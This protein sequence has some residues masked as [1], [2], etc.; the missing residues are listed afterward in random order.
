MIRREW[1]LEAEGQVT[2]EKSVFKPN[3]QRGRIDVHVNPGDPSVGVAVGEVKST[4]WEQMTEPAV[5]RNVRRQAKQIWAY[6]ESQLAE[7]HAVSPGVIF[8]ARPKSEVSNRSLIARAL[9]LSG[10][11]QRISE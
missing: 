7:G 3:G 8:P 6:I 10:A 2:V 4:S 5:R 11:T 1:G 9:S